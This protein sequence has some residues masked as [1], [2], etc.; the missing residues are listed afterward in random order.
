MLQLLH[1]DTAQAILLD[2]SVAERAR[3]LQHWDE[4]FTCDPL[5]WG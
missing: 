4:D 2:M 3:L 1:L 5:L